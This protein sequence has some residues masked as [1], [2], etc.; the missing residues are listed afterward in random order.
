MNARPPAAEL[1]L[2]EAR[3]AVVDVETTGGAIRDGDRITEIAVVHVER[4][5][6]GTVFSTLVNPERPIPFMIQRIT[7]I[8]DAM[9][10]SAPTFS[11]VAGLVDAQLDGRIFTAHNAPFDW[12]FVRSELAGSGRE[13]PEIERLCTVRMGRRF[14]PQLRSHGLD[15]L[16]GHFGIPVKGRH[17]AMGDALAT[18]HLLLHLLEA[19]RAEGIEEW[20]L[21]CDA[22]SG[23][24]RKK[25]RKRTRE[26]IE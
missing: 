2:A 9:V 16:T 21:L 1:P 10:G 12:G 26:T 4:S 6:I 20:T 7:G 8:T 17:R 19:A 14:L 23:R 18:A 3:F 13:R 5:E 22:I 24:R 11:E 15:A 25:K